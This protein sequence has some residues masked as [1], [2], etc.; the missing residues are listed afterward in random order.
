MPI[1]QFL[2][3]A[4]GNLAITTAVA[5]LPIMAMVG[6]AV[7][8]SMASRYQTRLQNA[9][10]SAT[11]AAGIDMTRMSDAEIAA[12]VNDYLQANLDER[13]H[14]QVKNVAV[15]TNRAALSLKVTVDGAFDT[16]FA[17]IIG[18]NELPY[19]G[20]ASI[21]R[22]DSGLE[23]VLVLDNTA[24][25]LE[26]AKLDGLKAAA[27]SFVTLLHDNAVSGNVPKVAIVPFSNYVNVGGDNRNAAWM[28]VPDDETKQV[29]GM[30]RDVVSKSGCT[31]QTGT[32]YNDGSPYT[33]NYETC[34][35]YEYGPEYQT[36]WQETKTWHGCAGSRDYPLNLK[37]E[38]YGTRI[39]GIMDGSTVNYL[40][41]SRIT[42]LTTDKNEL[43]NQISAMQAVG[44]TYI[45]SG[46][47][48]G[49]R[50]ISSKVPFAGGATPAEV[51]SGKVRKAL[52]LMT[53]G[54]NT[55][56]KN[57]SD[58]YHVGGDSAE[59]DAWT[60]EVCANVK[61][62]DISVFTMSF[63]SNVPTATKQLLAECSSGSGYFFDAANTAELH[64][65][66]QDIA[67][68]LNKLYLTQ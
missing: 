46:V 53:D 49:W 4:R 67:A 51:A 29:C 3:D 61:N 50:V 33:Y 13:D 28:S 47:V 10:D 45:P 6:L 34:T 66:F 43:L 55:L 37:D 30:T 63:G 25:M 58:E 56:S 65:A 9:V 54:Q 41:P 17:A 16:S 31:T 23:A 20:V 24:S 38:S 59:A 36:C 2:K 64:S 39:P 60:K 52:I 21:Q 18:I 44:N 40:C 68:K 7:D 48:W 14:G 62:E 35:N 27:S 12:V 57:P 8:Y 19:K 15:E 42:E 1:L 22:N 26:E 5:S 11:L 32:G